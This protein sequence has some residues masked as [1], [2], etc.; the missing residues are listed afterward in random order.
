MNSRN[1]KLTSSVDLINNLRTTLRELKNIKFPNKENKIDNSLEM[2][3]NL[4]NV[5]VV[6]AQKEFFKFRK[7]KLDFCPVYSFLID[8]KSVQP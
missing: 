2:E 3:L 8:S 7:N 6:K 1:N 5:K 4:V